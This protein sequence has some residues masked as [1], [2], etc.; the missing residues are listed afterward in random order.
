MLEVEHIYARKRNEFEP[1]K[2]RANLEALGNKAMLEKGVNIRAADFRFEDKRKY[3]LGFKDG[4]GQDKAGTRIRELAEMAR[5]CEDFT[6]ADIE[7]RTTKIIDSFV[8]YLG[9]VGLLTD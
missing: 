4:R 5:T 7:A 2:N 3:Y 1:L 8:S 6:E 9:E